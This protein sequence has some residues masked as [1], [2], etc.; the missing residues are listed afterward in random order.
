MGQVFIDD[1]SVNQFMTI[2]C[3]ICLTL[4]PSLV[5]IDSSG[6]FIFQNSVV[7]KLGSSFFSQVK[8]WTYL[9]S[10]LVTLTLRLWMTHI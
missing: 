1:I 4:W 8:G 6:I 10:L 3:E 5:K 9:H 7:K 2:E